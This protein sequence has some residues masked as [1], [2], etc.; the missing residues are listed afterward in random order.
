MK[1]LRIQK[2]QNKMHNITI[3]YT[4]T[5]FVSVL[6]VVTLVSVNCQELPTI[7]PPSPEAA[8]LAKFTEVP[9]SRY[10]GVPSISI[11]IHTIQ[12]KGV[13]IPISLNY[14]ARGIKVSEVSSR[15][16]LGWALN[17]GGGISRQTR[18]KADEDVDFG[19]LN[20][21][22][23]QSFF[24][25]STKRRSVMSTYYSHNDYDFTPDLFHFSANGISGKFIIDQTDKDVLVQEYDD[26][27]ME[28]T[29]SSGKIASFIIT[30]ASGNKYYYGISKDGT[31]IARNEDEVLE[32]IVYTE[33]NGRDRSSPD[34]ERY[35]N[36]WQLMD[37]ETIYGQIISYD[38]KRPETS[39][40]YRRSYDKYDYNSDLLQSFS[41]KVRSHQYQLKTINFGQG[42]LEFIEST[43]REDLNNSY[44]LDSINYF[45]Q[46]NVLVKSFELKYEYKT[47]PDDN[48]Q[49]GYLKTGDPKSNK[50]LF[51]KS[52]TQN[53][54]QGASLP[55][56]VF[57]YNPT[58]LP[59]RFSN[60]QDVWGY[61]NGAD[62]G[63]FLTF[64][65]Y[66][67]STINRK[68]DTVLSEAG[69]LK[70]MTLPTGGYMEFAYEQNRAVPSGFYNNLAFNVINPT[71]DEKLALSH[72]E[73]GQ[74]FDT[75]KG[76]Y[77]KSFTVG[78]NLLGNVTAKVSFTDD[79][80]CSSTSGVPPCK[81]RV[82]VHGTSLNTLLYLG[83]RNLVLSPGSYT[84]RVTPQN[85][86]HN[87]LDPN[88]GFMVHLD[89]VEQVV[90][91]DDL[92]YGPGKRIKK[93]TTY[94]S[95]N[96]VT[97]TRTYEY[98]DSTGISTG[99][100][101]GL[102]NF[103]SIAESTGPFAIFEPF[104]SVPGSPLS[105]PQGNT[106]GYG[107]VTEY[108][109][110]QSVNIG[111]TVYAF[112]NIEDS[113][114]Y[115]KFPYHLPTD[116]EWLRGKPLTVNYYKQ[117]GGNYTMVRKIENE[118]LYADHLFFD[119]SSPDEFT[120]ITV[121]TPIDTNLINPQATYLKNRRKFRLPL[122]IFGMDKDPITG[123]RDPT[124]VYYRTYHQTGGTLDLMKTTTTEYLDPVLPFVTT[125]EYLYD[126]D[127][128]YQLKTGQTTNSDGNIS[129]TTIFYPND[130]TELSG[131]SASA[132]FAI[133]SLL[134]SH[135]LAEPLQTNTYKGT[136]LLSKTR[137]NFLVT[138]DIAL[139]NTI[140]TARG[141]GG[142][143]TRVR[144][145]R[146]DAHG[147]PQEISQEDGM[148]IVYLWGYE[149]TLPVAQVQNATY[150]QVS[151][152]VDQTILDRP[153]SDDALRTELNKIRTSAHLKSALVTTMTYK[154]GVGMTS[155][156]GPNGI[157]TQ[158]EHDLFG[159]LMY[160]KD[161]EG[162]ILKK[163]EYYYG[164]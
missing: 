86:I 135:R 17:Y 26:I 83:N 125:T 23:L 6:L 148:H 43:E 48:N 73:Y 10:T 33:N 119:R 146:Y 147:N 116:N 141:T 97:G 30:D 50:R 65:S 160:V 41:S 154:Q 21:N 68:V 143:E 151:G 4:Q 121:N 1:E 131:L 28:Y 56:Y 13:S 55:S 134:S 92:I 77:E 24:I 145:H 108:T 107:E 149:S 140:E 161:Q 2:Y 57:D 71:S 59:N 27:K 35:Y 156:T 153:A 3:K 18:G 75:I 144:Y 69:M 163:H 109:G 9:V 44:V 114:D 25:S 15:V 60:S 124:T 5:W 102:P 101:H 16:G 52:I 11:P 152:I 36:S 136:T 103:Y 49:L 39:V 53:D 40:Y 164:E 111:K 89:W 133:D 80:G 130:K 84:L 104:G 138:N 54:G 38:Y 139:L 159:R 162:N 12:Q 100:L 81:F 87:H 63:S 70:K 34:N 120:P 95:P 51:L 29:I 46:D 45:N 132:A 66:G 32:N 129:K 74:Q 47:S 94:S 61:Y 105:T 42:R 64:F 20:N 155:Q 128:H 90:S 126:Y 112:T 19:Y 118:Y 142:L 117:I 14:H 122:I 98:K 127:D 37:I 62:N 67:S 96:Q 82:S 123:Q 150:S 137:N 88:H 106:I 113:G 58:L 99:K 93:I 157:T 76:Y 115:Y 31:R 91:E 110:E 158:Y 7:I 79:S 8:S 72:L 78:D 85:H 22:Y